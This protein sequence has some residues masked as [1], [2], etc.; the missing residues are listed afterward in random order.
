[1]VTSDT[2]MIFTNI[3]HCYCFMKVCG[4][5]EK[6]PEDIKLLALGPHMDARRYKGYIIN[7]C[8]FR[9]KDVDLRRK[10]QN[11]G[12]ML[13]AS[14][15]CFASRKDNNPVVGDVNFYG[16]LTDIIEIRY[17][18]SM[19]FVLFRC[20]WIDNRTG[21]LKD[22]FKFTLVNF[23]HKLYKDNRVTDEPF[24]LAT[25]AK[26]VWYIQDPLETDWHVVMKMTVRDNFDVYSTETSP[27]STSVPQIVPFD[28]QEFDDN[29]TYAES[30]WVREGV[31]GVEV[32]WP[33][34]TDSRTDDQAD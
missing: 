18:N 25:Q 33:E 3:I 7:G 6:I 27:N 29:Q 11:S 22:E 26:Q 20:D 31:E 4:T 24:I 10:S 32:P 28:T 2:F 34:E 13:N 16:Q 8:R 5:K 14:V 19:K 1:M 21:M 12:V 30:S 17:S 15:P 9:I 23:K